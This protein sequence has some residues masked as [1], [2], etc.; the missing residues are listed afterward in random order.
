MSLQITESYAE[1]IGTK[2]ASLM[3]EYEEIWE[4]N[5]ECFDENQQW[6]LGD[7]DGLAYDE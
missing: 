1:S 7:D 5:D 4:E 3:D 6:E 2:N